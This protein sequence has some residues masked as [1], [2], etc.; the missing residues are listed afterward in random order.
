MSGGAVAGGVQPGKRD[1]PLAGR[2]RSI[3]GKRKKKTTN[4]NIDMSL[5]MEV[6]ELLIERGIKL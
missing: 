4:E 2:S 5:V 1:G 6:Y 3:R